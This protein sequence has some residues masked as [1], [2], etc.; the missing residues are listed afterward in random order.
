MYKA[1]AVQLSKSV[2]YLM[3]SELLSLGVA[4]SY[5]QPLLHVKCLSPICITCSV[6][7]DAQTSVIKLSLLPGIVFGSSTTGE[8]VS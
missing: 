5:Q 1:L 7:Q 3:G 6:M 4:N 8:Q 2:S